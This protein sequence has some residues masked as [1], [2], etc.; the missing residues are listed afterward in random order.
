MASNAQGPA[1]RGDQREAGSA[2]PRPTHRRCHLDQHPTDRMDGGFH[3]WAGGLAGSSPEYTKLKD[4]NVG[5]NIF[6]G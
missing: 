3:R 2:A 5:T 4:P 1:F 6:S